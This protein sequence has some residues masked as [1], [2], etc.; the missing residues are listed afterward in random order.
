MAAGRVEF[1]SMFRNNEGEPGHQDNRWSKSTELYAKNHRGTPGKKERAGVQVIGPTNA[2]RSPIIF[3]EIGNHSNPMYEWIELKNVS[4]GNVNL[5]NYEV[6]IAT[7]K[8]AGQSSHN[9]VDLIDFTGDGSERSCG[10]YSARREVR[11]DR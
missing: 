8:G 4:G 11:S 5:K 6:T 10:R 2:N 9:D 1:I 7:T 3:N